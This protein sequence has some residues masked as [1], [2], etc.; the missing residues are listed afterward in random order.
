MGMKKT[1]ELAWQGKPYNVTINMELI[2]RIEDELNL[3]QM[4]AQ[5]ASGDTRMSKA[6][7]LFAIMLQ[8]AGC[9]VTQEDVYTGMYHS[10]AQVSKKQLDAA[11]AEVFNVMFDTGA[12]KKAAA[13]A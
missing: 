11:L 8:S 9:D 7:K 5:A 4:V 12:A 2:D 10:G 3:A 1:I 13:E 6:A